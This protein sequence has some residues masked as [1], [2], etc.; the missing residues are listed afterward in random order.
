MKPYVKT[1]KSD[2]VDAEAI[3]EAVSRPTMCFVPIKTDD[4]LELCL[5][6]ESIEANAKRLSR[7]FSAPLD[8]EHALIVNTILFATLAQT[9]VF[10]HGLFPHS[11]AAFLSLLAL[12]LP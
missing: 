12:S 4:Q 8:D 10:F 1:N 7:R 11:I 9:I 3:A 2:Y 6:P 5:S